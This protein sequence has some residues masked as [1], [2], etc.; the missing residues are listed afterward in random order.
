MIQFLHT[1]DWQ[2]GMKARHVASVGEAV[3]AA[4]FNAVR[5]LLQIAMEKQ[6]DFVVVAGDIFEHN[7][8]DNRLVHKLMSILEQCPLPIYILPGN[9]DPLTPDSIYWRPTL[10]NI[11]PSNV[12]IFTNPD[13]VEVLP[14]VIL[15]PSPNFS[16]KS[17]SDPTA[18]WSGISSGTINIGVAHGSLMIEGRHQSD[19]FPIALDIAERQKLDYLAL[20][21]WH[22][23]FSV[24]QRTFYSGT[25]EPTGFDEPGSGCALLVSI[26][27][28]RQEPKV[29]VIETGT[30]KW[31]MWEYDLEAGIDELKRW[32]KQWV[33]KLEKLETVLLRLVLSGHLSSDGSSQLEELGEWLAARLLY[34][35]IDTSRVLTQPVTANLLNMARSQPFV[36]ALLGDLR[37]TAEV[38]GQPLTDLPSEFMMGTGP[39]EELLSEI[40][41]KG[42]SAEDAALAIRVLARLSEEV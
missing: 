4:R 37:V 26:D 19:D 16:K 7:Q 15:L 23:L 29:E 41:K 10:T 14:G 3:R 11:L 2:I 18:I 33:E 40:I 20:G 9:H 22:S 34:V 30:L 25:P 17:A 38:L 24:G 28:P 36:Q 21:H 8:I 27:G 32:V 35:D 12:H 6:A 31:L 42:F 13:P 39:S 1:A 5:N